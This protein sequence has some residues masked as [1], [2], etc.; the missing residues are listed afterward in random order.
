MKNKYIIDLENIETIYEGEKIPVI[1]D[2]NL[3]I[4]N[5]EFVSIIGPNGAGK[6]T[7]LETINGLLHHTEG[8]GYVFGR[9]ILKKK[10]K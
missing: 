10:P 8:K 6:T 5:G 2:I 3:N 1:H 9:D 4:K 7:L